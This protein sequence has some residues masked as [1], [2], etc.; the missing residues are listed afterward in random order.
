MEPI[1]PPNPDPLVQLYAALAKAQ[2]K[3]DPVI[4][5]TLVNVKMKNGGSYDFKYAPLAQINEK[6]RPALTANGIA[7]LQPIETDASGE[8]WLIT[9]I[10]HEAGGMMENRIALPRGMADV[11]DFGATVTY[12]RRYCLS[13]MLGIAADSEPD[14]QHEEG[15]GEG[16]NK[17]AD[18]KPEKADPAVS[19]EAWFKKNLKSWE[20]QVAAGEK[21]VAQIVKYAESRNLSPGHIAR[22]KQIPQPE[23]SQ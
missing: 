1:I 3:F 12:L 9:R 11:K 23:A 10:V 7:V 20:A 14:E 16:G 13:S 17:P 19:A 5:D 22:I 4:A 6:T 18:N 21:T 8:R 15:A 2:S